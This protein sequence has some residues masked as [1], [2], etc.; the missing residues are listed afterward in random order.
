[1]P[2]FKIH[3]EFKMTG[4]QPQAVETLANGIFARQAGA[5]PHGRHRLRQDLHHGQHHRAGAEADPGHFPQ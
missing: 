1:M 4:D 3:S 5:D 2:E